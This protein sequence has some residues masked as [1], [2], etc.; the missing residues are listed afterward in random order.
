[1][2]GLMNFLLKLIKEWCKISLCVIGDP[3]V[4]YHDKKTKLMDF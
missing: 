4:V 1:M 2:T 3:P